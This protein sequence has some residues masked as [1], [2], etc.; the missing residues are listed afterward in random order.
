MDKVGFR[1]FYEIFIFYF[2]IDFKSFFYRIVL[3]FKIRY[4]SYWWGVSEWFEGFR[5]G[6][7]G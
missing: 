2:V 6:I 5:V 7:V 4:E 3:D 1:K